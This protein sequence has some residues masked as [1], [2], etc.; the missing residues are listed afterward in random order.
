M[1][2]DPY[3]VTDASFLAD[4]YAAYARMRSDG[5]A[6]FVEAWG[7]WAITHYAAVVAG[8]RDPRLSANR[9]G[10]LASRLPPAARERVAPFIRNLSS[11]ALLVD[12]PDHTR[13]RGLINKAFTP[14]VAERLR[15][16]IVEIARL[17]FDD[18]LGASPR[19]KDFDLVDA[20]ATPLPVI[21][22]G[23]LLGL[24]RAD[25]H[26]LKRWSDALAAAMG[27]A[28]ANIELAVVA[29]DAV[30]DMEAYFREV[31]EARRRSPGDDLL[32][33]LIAARDDGRLLSDDELL[34]T[35][36]MILFGGHETTSNL[37]A[38]GVLALLRFP[39]QADRLRVVA[40]DGNAAAWTL[41]ID[42]LLRFD[43]PVQRI[44]RIS[45]EA[46]DVGGARIPA[47]ERVFLLM[48]AAHHDEKVFRDPDRLDLSRDEEKP[49]S[50]GIGVHYC[51]GAAL[52]RMEAEIAIGE[53]LRRA[54]RL[55]LAD[56]DLHWLD[57]ATVR[58]VEKLVVSAA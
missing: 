38:N 18:V 49:L 2:A 15:P 51:V 58:G 53:L 47:G 32:S 27:S 28:R 50:F 46:I 40:A 35:C 29:S 33:Q 30:V 25:R 6:C 4:P 55:T 22:I 48:G 37:V 11:W 1:A 44:G 12:P 5:P 34:A 26:R 31:L 3:G 45:R 41:A 43:S 56:S 16:A 24:P 19:A 36:S 13:L 10:A 39:A 23:D 57:N 54:P 17:L 7:A 20:I 21:V 8:F 52:G 9:A 42:E 14:R